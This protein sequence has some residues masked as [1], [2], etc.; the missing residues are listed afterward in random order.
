MPEAWIDIRCPEC[1]EHWEAD[2]VTLPAP[3]EEFQ[4]PQ[5]DARRSVSEFMRAKRD[6]E[7]LKEFHSE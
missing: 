3:D 2:P 4:C 6:L 1:E 7:V 5:C